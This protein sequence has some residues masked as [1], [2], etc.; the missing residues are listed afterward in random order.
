VVTKTLFNSPVPREIDRLGEASAVVMKRFTKQWSSLRLL[1][2]LLPRLSSHRFERVVRELDEFIYG[3]IRERRASG[4][5]SGD[6]LSMFLLARDESGNGMSD[7][8]VRDELTTLMLAGLD[9][10]ALA[11]AW[12]FYLLAKNPSADQK[13]AA[14]LESVLSG[15]LPQL[16]DLP[17]LRYT[18]S[19]VKETMRLYPS[20]WVIGREAV[21]ACEVGGH[22]I[23]AG[24][25]LLMSQ[26]LKHRDERFFERATTFFPERWSEEKIKGL[27]KYAYFPF[28]SGPRICIGASFASME[29]VLVLA[30]VLQKFRLRCPPEYC[31]IPWPSIT[32]QPK[33]GIHLIVERRIRKAP[34]DLPKSNLSVAPGSTA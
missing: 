15:R 6:L 25:A 32:L 13:V 18:E 33:G 30:T 9:T 10:T 19:V 28:G 14:E 23:A 34:G 11:L 2:N 16:A 24:S 20:A 17:C 8:Q 29:T 12:A 22:R 7:V 5:D 27:P 31:V 1:V 21:Q 4:M 26:W 3:I